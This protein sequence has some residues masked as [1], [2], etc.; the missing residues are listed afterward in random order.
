MPKFLEN[1]KKYKIETPNG[2]EHFD[3]IRKTTKDKYC[4]ILFENG[5]TLVASLNHVFINDEGEEVVAGCL[6]TGDKIRNKYGI[7]KVWTVDIYDKNTEFFD[8]VNSGKD[9]VFYSN[10]ILS[11]NCEFLG[12]SN[13]LIHPTTLQSLAHVIP[14]YASTDGFMEVYEKPLPKHTYMC[15]VDV[16]HG[17]NQD[18]SVVAAIDI[19]MSPYKLV[20]KYRN[21]TISPLMLPN[22][23][24]EIAKKYNDAFVLVEVNDIGKQVADIIHEE[25]EYENLL[26]TT[27][28][29]RG[30][31]LLGLGYGTNAQLGVKTT[32]QT[33]RIGCVNVKSL[34]EEQKLIIQDMDTIIELSTFVSKGSSYEAEEGSHDDLIMPLVLFAWATTQKYFKDLTDVN[35]RNKMYDESIKALE[36][37]MLPYGYFS[38]GRS[39]PT[40]DSFKDDEGTVWTYA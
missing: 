33:K 37:H 14:I 25:L 39:D 16:S 12:S 20:A 9:H 1:I 3:G 40:G 10:N 35:I 4:E 18:F 32:K 36:E 6:D 28:R 5:V 29:G 13:T 31:Q 26:T 2:F 19:T 27:M 34:I 15:V 21:N 38:D 30:G 7:T 23:T 11:H 8:I 17:Y 22:V 24:Y